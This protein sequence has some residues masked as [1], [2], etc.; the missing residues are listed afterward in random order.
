MFHLQRV[1]VFTDKFKTLIFIYDHTCIIFN[2][3]GPISVQR[4][5][6]YLT[7]YI[8]SSINPT[9]AEICIRCLFADLE[10]I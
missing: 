1:L 10:C 6:I 9:F 4:I 3:P 5:A 7:S 2:N 8:Y